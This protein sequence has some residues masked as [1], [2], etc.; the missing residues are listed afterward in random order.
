MKIHGTAK[1]A[2]LS[3]KDFGVAF[4]GVP[5]RS[6][7][8][9]FTGAGPYSDAALNGGVIARGEWTVDSTKWAY[10]TNIALGK[11]TVGLRKSDTLTGTVSCKMGTIGAGTSFSITETSSTTYGDSDIDASFEDFDF[12]FANTNDLVNNTFVAVFYDADENLIM[13]K[14]ATTNVSSQGTPG[15]CASTCHII[16]SAITDETIGA[17]GYYRSMDCSIFNG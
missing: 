4:G 1:G 5:P 14:D 7:N 11:F 13:G 17:S 8:Q 6:F 2:A 15:N 10:T 16:G 12:L 9:M 3:T